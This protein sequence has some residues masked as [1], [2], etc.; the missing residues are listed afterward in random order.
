MV[1]NI[2]IFVQNLVLAM[3]TQIISSLGRGHLSTML[4]SGRL[5]LHHSDLEVINCLCWIRYPPSSRFIA[6]SRKT[7]TN[8]PNNQNKLLKPFLLRNVKLCLIV[9]PDVPV[10]HGLQRLLVCV[11]L[12][13][14]ISTF[15][16]FVAVI[17]M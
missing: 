4:T 1:S 9:E 6:S 15:C 7:Q 14:I 11:V 10:T 17:W 2:A 12:V 13:V 16:V 3:S 8:Q 5:P